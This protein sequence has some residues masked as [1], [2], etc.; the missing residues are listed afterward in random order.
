MAAKS[1]G[2]CV[3]SSS[4]AEMPLT[5]KAGQTVQGLWGAPDAVPGPLGSTQWSPRERPSPGPSAKS[6]G[7]LLPGRDGVA[8]SMSTVGT[9][10]SSL[11][12]SWPRRITWEGAV[13]ALTL[14]P[15]RLAVL[16]CPFL[17]FLNICMWM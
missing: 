11:E 1:S 7:I 17:L 8:D 5:S 9:I 12:S 15:E 4:F 2:L 3:S 13:L 6:N 16:P 14:T 10:C